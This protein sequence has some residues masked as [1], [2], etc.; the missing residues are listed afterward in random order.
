MRRNGCRDGA[1]IPMVPPRIQGGH[2]RHGLQLVV[3]L[4]I[5]RS[6]LELC[7]GST[8]G[9]GLACAREMMELGADVAGNLALFGFNRSIVASWTPGR[10]GWRDVEFKT[11]QLLPAL[12]GENPEQS[13]VGVITFLMEELSGGNITQSCVSG[14]A[15]LWTCR[16]P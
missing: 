12:Q 3:T 15:L 16:L 14:G 8:K 6:K 7:G 11:Y 1:Y 2:Y 4:P 9:L 5:T 10:A 13:A